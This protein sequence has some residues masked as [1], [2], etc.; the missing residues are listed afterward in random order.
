MGEGILVLHQEYKAF[1]RNR[2]HTK[3]KTN[4]KASVRLHNN[5][6]KEVWQR[7]K[8]INDD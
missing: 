7:V 1:D 5:K 4:Y 3:V 2:I 6:E 8:Q